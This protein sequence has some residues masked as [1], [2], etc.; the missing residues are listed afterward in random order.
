M[1]I[2]FMMIICWDLIIMYVIYIFLRGVLLSVF[3]KIDGLIDLGM[4]MECEFI[5]GMNA[6]WLWIF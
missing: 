5:D 6:K 2:I 1:K 4:H 3:I